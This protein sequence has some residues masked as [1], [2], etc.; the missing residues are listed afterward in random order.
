MA[1]AVTHIFEYLFLPN[2]EWEKF[3]SYWVSKNVLDFELIDWNL[4]SSLHWDI[5][6]TIY[7]TID[8]Y[9]TIIFLQAKKK[10]SVDM[11]PA[12]D[13]YSAGICDR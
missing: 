3:H 13:I 2:L 5:S 9:T 4:C 8:A 1:F 12:N 6:Q 11:L 7:R 10:N